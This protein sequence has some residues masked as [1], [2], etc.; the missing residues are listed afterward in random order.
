MIEYGC[1]K[2]ITIPSATRSLVAELVRAVSADLGIP[3]PRIAWVTDADPA[4]A[5]VEHIRAMGTRRWEFGHA[6]SGWTEGW[7][8]R[9]AVVYLV[10]PENDR[11]VVPHELRHVWQRQAGPDDLLSG[12][13]AEV[14]AERYARRFLGLPVPARDT[15]PDATSEENAIRLAERDLADSVRADRI[16]AEN[17]ELEKVRRLAG[18]DCG[19]SAGTRHRYTRATSPVLAARVFGVPIPEG[20]ERRIEHAE[21]FGTKR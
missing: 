10:W 15:P 11:L 19:T 2:D 9:S 20:P 14:D 18:S 4:R 16:G 12:P 7:T 21:R 6:L 8:P 5:S 3:A 1:V 13:A 17:R